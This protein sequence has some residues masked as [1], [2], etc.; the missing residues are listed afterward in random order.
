MT[1]APRSALEKPP[2]LVPITSRESG[3]DRDGFAKCDQLA[4]LPVVL[5]GPRSGRLS[6]G[7]IERLDAG[8]RFVLDL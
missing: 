7:S 2:Y 3:L 4:T 1:S 6:P 5:L 8:L